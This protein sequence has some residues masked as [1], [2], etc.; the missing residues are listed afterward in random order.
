MAEEEK[1]LDELVALVK[2]A[3]I[4]VEFECKDTVDLL[5]RCSR[6]G[7]MGRQPHTTLSQSRDLDEGSGLYDYRKESMCLVRKIQ[8][9]L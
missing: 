8:G 7:R 1:Q 3:A 5:M 9:K 6:L 2:S 4:K